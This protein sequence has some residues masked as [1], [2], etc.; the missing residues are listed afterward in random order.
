[1]KRITPV[2]MTKPCY[3]NRPKISPLSGPINL[4]LRAFCGFFKYFFYIK[5][6]TKGPRNEVE[7]RPNENQQCKERSKDVKI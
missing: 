7:G 5:K 6:A 1:M 2:E 3:A 4:V